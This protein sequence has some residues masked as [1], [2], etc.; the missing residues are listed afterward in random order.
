M[1]LQNTNTKKLSLVKLTL[2]KINKW[3]L[4][5]LWIYVY[6]CT[7][8]AWILLIFYTDYILIL[9]FTSQK[10]KYLF[11]NSKIRYCPIVWQYKLGFFSYYKFNIWK[12]LT[13]IE[14]LSI[15]CFHFDIPQISSSNILHKIFSKFYIKQE[16][17]IL[18]SLPAL[19]CIKNSIIYTFS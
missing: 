19:D 3:S 5:Q 18:Q 1:K 17:E 10:C 16:N 4:H 7:I 14:H 2:H 9:S 15:K 11:V 8:P 13:S 12:K 6:P